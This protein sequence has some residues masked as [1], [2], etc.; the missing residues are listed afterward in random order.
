MVKR[1][2]VEAQ[3]R[4]ALQLFAA[5]AQRSY[6]QAQD[7]GIPPAQLKLIRRQ[8]Q[9]IAAQLTTKVRPHT[10]THPDTSLPP[11][12]YDFPPHPPP[13]L[14]PSSPPQLYSVI[15]APVPDD[16]DTPPP[17]PLPFPDLP[18]AQQS[19]LRDLH[20]LSTLQQRTLSHLTSLPPLP[21][22]HS[23]TPHRAKRPRPSSSSSLPSPPSSSSSS[24][25]SSPSSSDVVDDEELQ[26]LKELRVEVETLLDEVGEAVR[27][28]TGETREMRRFVE[29]HPRWEGGTGGGGGGGGEGGEEEHVKV[30]RSMPHTA[31]P[32]SGHSKQVSAGLARRL[33]GAQGQ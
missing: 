12:P 15:L 7:D 26:R 32:S 2:E 14:P 20:S 24:S 18:S 8:L 10:H 21:L 33:K 17:P 1:V 31:S 4:H 23:P 27:K 3:L 5:Q 22:P 30:K 19:I 11:P 13:P 29:G 25:S 28:E 6:Q 9:H 16:I